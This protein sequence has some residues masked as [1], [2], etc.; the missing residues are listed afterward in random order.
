MLLAA[1]AGSLLCTPLKVRLPSG[2]PM[3]G[4]REIREERVG[5][6]SLGSGPGHGGEFQ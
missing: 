4:V 5:I 3:G 6:P 1:Q 2:I